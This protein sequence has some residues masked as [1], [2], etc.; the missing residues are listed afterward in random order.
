MLDRSSELDVHTPNR[1]A[2]PIIEIPL[3]DHSHI[4]AVGQLL[5]ERGV[6]VTLA[7][8]PLVPRAEVGFRVQLTAANTDAEVD[9]LIAA[10]RDLDARGELRHVDERELALA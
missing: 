8:Y 10:L 9:T 1:S 6:Y 7:R 4:D 5:F 3:R 2:M